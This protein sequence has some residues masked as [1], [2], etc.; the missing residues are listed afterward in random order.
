V[1]RRHRR[2]QG[3][4]S[5]VALR[6][7]LQRKA[8]QEMSRILDEYRSLYRTDA[9]IAMVPREFY[10]RVTACWEMNGI[11]TEPKLMIQGQRLLAVART[12]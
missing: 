1:H 10:D 5:T 3:I 9:K 11:P 7:E 8:L 12:R 6:T 4:A 2:H